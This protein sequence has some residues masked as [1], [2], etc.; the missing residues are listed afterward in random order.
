MAGKFLSKVIAGAALGGVSLL[1]APGIA[2][3][4]GG[5]DHDR[6]DHHGKIF[7]HPKWA[8][9]GHE[10]TI[11]EICPEPQ[12]HAWAWSKVTGKLHLAPKKDADSSKDGH[13]NWYGEHE[14]DKKDKKDSPDAT[15]GKSDTKHEDGGKQ[16]SDKKYEENGDKGS[17]GSGGDGSSSKSEKNDK[18][19]APKQDQ[20]D[21]NGYNGN[22]DEYSKK[23]KGH[24]ESNKGDEH[25]A[26]KS[27]DKDDKWKS[28]DEDD[29]YVYTTTVTIPWDTKPGRYELK[30]SCASG[31]LIVTPKG[32]VD[33]GDGGA[34]GTNPMLAAGGAGMLGAA[35]LGA[36][37]LVRRRR[38]DGSLA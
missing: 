29:K 27:D 23:D 4:D 18:S 5:Y 10:V 6:H 21:K 37:L 8:K 34:T 13:E 17:H 35:A 26:P 3:A 20:K 22:K 12:E 24:E 7:A 16:Q 33:G 30:G 1:F 32:W 11:L 25:G 36:I 14:G 9:T 19:P 2:V 28:G 38:T 31:T 15:K